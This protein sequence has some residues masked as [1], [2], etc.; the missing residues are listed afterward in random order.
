MSKFEYKE[1]SV[2]EQSLY[3]ASNKRWTFDIIAQNNL[4]FCNGFFF[5]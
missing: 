2:C 5:A 3:N 4:Q 1:K